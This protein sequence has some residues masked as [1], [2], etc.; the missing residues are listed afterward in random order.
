MQQKGFHRKLIVILS[1]DVAGCSRL[2]QDN[3]AATVK[4]LKPYKTA[5]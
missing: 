1:V 4:I 2:M 5:V 3:E